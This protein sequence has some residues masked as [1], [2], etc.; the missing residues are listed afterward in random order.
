MEDKNSLWKFP[1]IID[2]YIDSEYVYFS[3]FQYNSFFRINRNDNSIENL[4]VFDGFY[5]DES[6][7]ARSIYD[8]DG[9]LYIFSYRSYEIVSYDLET[10]EKKYFY[11]EENNVVFDSVRCTLR[12]GNDIW[13]F[14]ECT[15]ELV[16]VFSLEEEKYSFYDFSMNDEVLES[17][18]SA[19]HVDIQNAFLID[20]IIWRCVCSTNIMIGYNVCTKKIVLKK[21]AENISLLGMRVWDENVYFT[22]TNSLD[23]LCYDKEFNLCNVYKS[24]S[25]LRKQ[26]SYW[27]VFLVKDKLYVLPC[28][29]NYIMCHCIND[30]NIFEKVELPKEF[31]K[32]HD[33]NERTLFYNYYYHDDRLILF[34]FAGNGLLELDVNTNIIKYIPLEIEKEQYI[35]NIQQNEK[36]ILLKRLEIKACKLGK[37]AH[38]NYG[39]N[40]WNKINEGM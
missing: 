11:P 29:E 16:A 28:F 25:S 30:R 32:V 24:Q 6:W 12:V 9:K 14:R 39:E 27:D 22:Q 1:V 13:I 34:P 10:G 5:H 37:T 26:Y 18:S 38:N 19:M 35:K 23:I 40:I 2:S 20:N 31:E 15:N 3:N 4:G 17:L 7:Q 33:I 21:L 8:Y 36:N